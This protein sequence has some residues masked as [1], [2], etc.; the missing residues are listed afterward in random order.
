MTDYAD[1]K[2][3]LSDVEHFHGMMGF[4]PAI[5]I[6]SIP[7]GKAA[8]D[9]KRARILQEEIKELV[10]AIKLGDKAEILHEGIDAL[11]VVLGAL[12]EAGITTAELSMG[13]GLVQSA[14][15]SKDAPADPLDKAIKGPNFEAA[16]CSAA[17]GAK[18]EEHRYGLIIGSGKSAKGTFIVNEGPLTKK[19]FITVCATVSE[20]GLGM[21]SLILELS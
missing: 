20:H 1:A 21:P 8:I 18:S 16:N 9:A 4:F 12:H 14:N 13:W 11:Y 6:E 17:L 3:M 15:M 5:E 19:D 7:G 10:E 2:R